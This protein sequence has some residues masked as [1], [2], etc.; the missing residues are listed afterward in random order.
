MLFSGELH[1]PLCAEPQNGATEVDAELEDVNA[2][3]GYKSIGHFEFV[4]KCFI[5]EL[6]RRPAE[7][8]ETVLDVKLWPPEIIVLQ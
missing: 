1:S 2:F 4:G 5:D 8:I 6:I 3:K 7:R